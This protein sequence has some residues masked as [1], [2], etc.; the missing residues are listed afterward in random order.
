MIEQRTLAGLYEQ[1]KNNATRKIFKRFIVEYGW[2]AIFGI[3]P[4]VMIND[5][6]YGFSVSPDDKAVCRQFYED[7]V[8]LITYSVQEGKVFVF[9]RDEMEVSD[10]CNRMT[11]NGIKACTA[12]GDFGEGVVV[13]EFF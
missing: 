1:Y 6:K 5:E 10:T 13:Y 2:D 11:P 12:E 7:C 8:G 9:D 4:L 3:R